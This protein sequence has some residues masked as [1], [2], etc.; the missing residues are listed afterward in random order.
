[1]LVGCLHGVTGFKSSYKGFYTGPIMVTVRV[2]ANCVQW[3]LAA[4]VLENSRVF[5][6]LGR[7]VGDF[8]GW[9]MLQ[10]SSGLGARI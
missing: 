4:F 10:K 8:Y 6:A 5:G 1:M 9:K 2:H 3:G 7:D